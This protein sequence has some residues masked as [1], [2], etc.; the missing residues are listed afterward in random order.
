MFEMRRKER[1]AGTLR[2]EEEGEAGWNAK[3]EEEEGG[4]G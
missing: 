1:D 2:D 4:R 3:S